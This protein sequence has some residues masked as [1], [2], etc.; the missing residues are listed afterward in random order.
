MM[1]EGKKSQQCQQFQT[2]LHIRKDWLQKYNSIE[3]VVDDDSRVC[4][5]ICDKN[6]SISHRERMTLQ[7]MLLAPFIKQML[8]G[9]ILTN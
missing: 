6:F 9:K 7:G 3:L 2:N 5:K 4:C 1:D 8:Y